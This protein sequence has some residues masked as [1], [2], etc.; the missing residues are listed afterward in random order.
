MGGTESFFVSFQSPSRA[1]ACGSTAA[2]RGLLRVITYSKLRHQIGLNVLPHDRE[3][4]D[5]QANAQLA[6]SLHLEA[7]ARLLRQEVGLGAMPGVGKDVVLDAVVL[8]SQTKV[9]VV[10]VQFQRAVRGLRR[11]V[12]RALSNG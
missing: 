1:A 3:W 2:S 8:G 10:A 11:K 7:I 9:R 12:G 5:H 4:H 6:A